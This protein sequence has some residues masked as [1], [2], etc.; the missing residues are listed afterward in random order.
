M[1]RVV[2]KKSICKKFILFYATVLRPEDMQISTFYFD[3]FI[4]SLKLVPHFQYEV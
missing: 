4:K 3:F 2:R 1:K